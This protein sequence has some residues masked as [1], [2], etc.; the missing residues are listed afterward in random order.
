MAPRTPTRKPPGVTAPFAPQ[1]EPPPTKPPVVKVEIP[2]I[3]MKPGEFRIRG[4]APYVQNRFGSRSPGA[5]EM[6]WKQ[7]NPGKKRKKEA[8]DFDACYEA[9]KHVSTEGWCG[10]PAA[11]FRSAMIRACS[12]IPGLKMTEAKMTVFVL[13][14]GYG[15]DG[16]PLV[17]IT[18]GEPHKVEHVVRVQMTTDLHARAMW[19][20]GWEAT[21]RV[22][23]DEAQFE[24]DSVANL[25]HRAGKQVGVGEGRPFSR[26][27]GGMG[28][29]TF[30]V[31]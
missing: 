11:A 22:R 1:V 5:E 2:P 29:G 10:I 13:A 21:V 16:T 14:D 19:D 4:D 9:S 26:S 7:E 18:K 3:K 24:I 28:W 6:K 25:L 20:P 12:L 30:D 23:F 15:T 31:L 8:K 17:R 27:S